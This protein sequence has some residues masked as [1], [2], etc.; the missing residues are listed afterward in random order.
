M[1]NE[2]KPYTVKFQSDFTILYSDGGLPVCYPFDLG[3]GENGGLVLGRKPTIDGGR[4]EP[5]LA[6]IYSRVKAHLESIGHKL[7]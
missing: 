4:S 1:A 6:E 5:E 7:V 3:P 2:D